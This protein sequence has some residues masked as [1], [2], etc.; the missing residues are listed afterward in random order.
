[1]LGQR[2]FTSTRVA[3]ATYLIPGISVG[4]IS[5][6][7]TAAANDTKPAPQP[8]VF[9]STSEASAGSVSTGSHRPAGSNGRDGL[10]V[11]DDG[12]AND[13]ATN[14]KIKGNIDSIVTTLD[15]GFGNV[16]STTGCM[17]LGAMQQC[18][19]TVLVRQ[20]GSR[21]VF[22]LPF[23]NTAPNVVLTAIS[24]DNNIITISEIDKSGFMAKSSN[25]FEN[26]KVSFANYIAIGLSQKTN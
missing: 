12:G 5:I 14:N 15:M 24:S 13:R 18:W 21:H 8:K 20:N 4:I 6:A 23:G 7:L 22:R 17:Q 2:I 10:A 9:S 1:M 11:I 16:K 26:K 25:P 3:R 19:G